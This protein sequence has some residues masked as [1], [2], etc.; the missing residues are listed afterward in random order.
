[1]PTKKRRQHEKE[2]SEMFRDLSE[3][4]EP[5]SEFNKRIKKMKKSGL[6]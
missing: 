6:F 5:F 4:N 2:R 1:M 3:P